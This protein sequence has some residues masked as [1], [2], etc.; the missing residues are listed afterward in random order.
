MTDAHD[1]DRDASLRENLAAA[2][3]RG[4]LGQVRPGEVPTT[5][6]LVRAVGGIRGLVESILPS[7]IFLVL[8][9]AT[10][11]LL[12]AVL[13]PVGVAA[14]FV[15]VRLVTRSQPVQ[16]IAGLVGTLLSALLALWTGRAEDNFLL[17][18]W[19]NAA[20]G[21]A[22]LVSLIMRW[23]LIGG[24]VGLLTQEGSA[25]RADA[26]KRRVLTVATWLWLGLFALRLAVQVPLYLAGDAAALA[27]TKL[28][29]GVPVYAVLLWVTWL[30]VRS[31]YAPKSPDARAAADAG[32]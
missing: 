1:S 26:A 9:T 21:A 32:E 4:G 6:S 12:P 5:A 13:V 10:G 23:P 22:I 7:L 19:T 11:E 15:I 30:L 16:A 2:A 18:I 25:W 8:Y 29:L 31:V 27:A 28:V 3:A 14:L 17:G 24:I 20:Y